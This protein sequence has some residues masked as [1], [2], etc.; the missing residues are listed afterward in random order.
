MLEWLDL[1]VAAS[2]HAGDVD[3]IMSLVHWLMLVLFVGWSLFFVYVLVRFRRRR[4][5]T[6]NYHGVKAR[7]ASWVGGACS[8]PRLCCSSSSPFRL[9]A[10]AWTHFRR[11]A[12]ARWFAW[13]PSSS[14]GT[15]ITQVPTACL[16][17]TSI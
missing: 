12:A 4:H 6:A 13:W 5:P 10:P 14:R 9:G 11:S 3:R 8:P 16:V 7:W 2:A 17:R 15:S 1:P